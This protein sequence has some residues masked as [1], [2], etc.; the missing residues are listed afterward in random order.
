MKKTR[1]GK[2]PTPA[3]IKKTI[4]GVRSSGLDVFQVQV[5][6]DGSITISSSENSLIASRDDFEKWE[7]RL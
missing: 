4:L 1:S 7:S 3:E 5:G 2:F 6:S